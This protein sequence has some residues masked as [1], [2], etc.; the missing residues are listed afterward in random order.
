MFNEGQLKSIL[1]VLFYK[2]MSFTVRVLLS[3]T[4]S[5]KKSPL[6]SEIFI[7]AQNASSFAQTR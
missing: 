2:M 5:L 7:Y 3:I 4:R 1:V 6:R